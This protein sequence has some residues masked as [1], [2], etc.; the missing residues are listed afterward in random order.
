[1]AEIEEGRRMSFVAE[2]VMAKEIR[3]RRE[4]FM[5][6]FVITYIRYDVV[7]PYPS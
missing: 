5:I 6:T 1:M 4:N 3:E 7:V 2:A